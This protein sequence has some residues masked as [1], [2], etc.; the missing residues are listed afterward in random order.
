AVMSV[1]AIDLYSHDRHYVK[2][3]KGH[4]SIPPKFEELL[5]SKTGDGRIGIDLPFDIAINRELDDIGFFDSIMLASTYRGLFDLSLAPKGHN[6]QSIDASQ[7][8]PRALRACGVHLVMSTRD[9]PGGKPI[10]R[11]ANV[12]VYELSDVA[13]RVEAFD[14]ASARYLEPDELEREL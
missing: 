2:S 11:E 12:R 7:L 5:R 14:A 10:V 9:W 6:T 8:D 3:W 13:A 4:E 1:H